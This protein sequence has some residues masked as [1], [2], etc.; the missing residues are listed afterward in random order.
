M[1][2]TTMGVRGIKLVTGEEVFGDV[3][4]ME[5]GRFIIKNPVALRMVPSQIQG[6]QPGMAFVPFPQLADEN[7]IEMYIEPLHIVYQYVPYKEL[8]DEYNNLISGKAEGVKQ[9]I[10]G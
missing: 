10:T 2:M 4:I 5:D 3:Q 1:A 7:F 8:I 9:I 6:G